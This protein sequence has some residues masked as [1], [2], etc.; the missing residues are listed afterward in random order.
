MRWFW[1]KAF[2]WSLSL[3]VHKGPN[4]TANTDSV[5]N[6]QNEHLLGFGFKALKIIQHN[7]RTHYWLNTAWW[8]PVR[9]TCLLICECRKT[10]S[11]LTP[12]KT[13]GMHITGFIH[14]LLFIKQTLKLYIVLVED[15]LDFPDYPF[16]YFCRGPVWPSITQTAV[17]SV[18]MT[19]K[20]RQRAT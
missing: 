18:S 15:E 8:N 1:D 4:S 13:Q 19:W 17:L 2:D 11:F 12:S 7:Q 10:L 3:Y 6:F 9:T 5:M 14:R 20:V 16:D